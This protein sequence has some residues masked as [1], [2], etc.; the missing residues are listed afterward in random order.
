MNLK[1]KSA[2]AFPVTSLSSSSK[3]GRARERSL[4]TA[5]PRDGLNL[6]GLEESIAF[7][8]RLA[9]AASFAAFARRADEAGLR[10]GHYAILHLIA[11]N[12]GVAQTALGRAS[13]RDKSTLTPILTDLSRRGFVI[14]ESCTRDRRALRLSLTSEGKEKLAM[15]ARHASAHDELLDS[16]V[17]PENKPVLIEW[18]ARIA[19]GLNSDAAFTDAPPTNT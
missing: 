18:L 7:S 16:L 8:L 1:P 15:L 14:R 12:P 19:A 4:E 9:Q 13:G 2:L 5:P 6:A 10:P 11:V 17:G 3:A